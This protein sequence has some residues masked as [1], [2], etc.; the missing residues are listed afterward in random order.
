MYKSTKKLSKLRK[1]QILQ[2]SYEPECVISELANK[3]GI[4][5][6]AIYGWRSKNKTGSEMAQ[7]KK[8]VSDFVELSVPSPAKDEVSLKRAILEFNNLSVS[9]D[10]NIKSSTLVQMLNILEESC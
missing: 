4:S 5:P 6:R 2:E 10:G 1:A 7:A 8:P 3:Y 9:I